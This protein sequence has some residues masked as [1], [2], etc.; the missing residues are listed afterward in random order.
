MVQQQQVK[1]PTGEPAAQ[2]R[3]MRS[4]PT[5]EAATGAGPSAGTRG[6]S[7]SEARSQPGQCPMEVLLLIRPAALRQCDNVLVR[8][9][10]HA[11]MC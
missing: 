6:R 8:V 9:C 11:I 5:Q 1:S 2:V 10:G 3:R 4:E 7:D